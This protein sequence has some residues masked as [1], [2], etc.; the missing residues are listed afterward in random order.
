[1]ETPREKH[2]QY[3]KWCLEA[4]QGQGI[5]TVKALPSPWLVLET[6]TWKVLKVQRAQEGC[7]LNGTLPPQGQVRPDDLLGNH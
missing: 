4:G 3:G 5:S 1:M 6:G 2:P 7:W